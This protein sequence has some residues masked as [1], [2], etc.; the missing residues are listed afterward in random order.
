MTTTFIEGGKQLLGTVSVSGAKNSALKLIY[1]SMLC[2]ES[3]IL[4]NVPNIGI[5]NS[6]LEIIRSV[7][8]IAEWTGNNRLRLSGASL[9]SYQVPYEIGSINRTSLLMAGPLLF[10]F[11]K[12]FIPKY[13]MKNFQPGPI[14]R[15]IETWKTLGVVI[16]EDSQYLKLSGDAMKPAS[17]VFK[18]SSHMATDNALLCASFMLGESTITNAS[19]ESEIDD[20]IG[21]L[22]GMGVSIIRSDPRSLKIQG[23][24]IFRSAGYSVQPDRAEAAVFATGAVITKGNI[25]IKNINKNAFIPFAN[26]L[27]KIGVRFD[28]SGN[29]VKVWRNDEELQ[30]NTINVSPSPGFIPEWQSLATLI[31]TQVTGTSYVHDTVYTDRFDYIKDLNRMGAKIELVKP[32]SVNI[33]PVI[34]NDLYSFETTG[35]PLTVA[36]INGPTKLKAERLHVGD[37]RSGAVL[38]L[39]AL[40]A[41]GKSEII[42]LENIENYFEHFTSKLESLGAKIWRQ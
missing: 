36:K 38:P 6:E 32:S 24:N 39:A 3:V 34:S 28:F 8:G 23:T 22:T 5:I 35:E 30:P 13:K 7:G 31:F 33:V 4:E 10:R 40:C 20:L 26:F 15:F 37:F 42:G 1:A 14:N 21:L 27:N 29:E 2:N 18:T 25:I 11:G 12:A 16:E 17:I 19:E 9:N 41:D